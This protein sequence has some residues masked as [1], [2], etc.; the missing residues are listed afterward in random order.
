[1][2]VV[3]EQADSVLEE[4]ACTEVELVA[5]LVPVAEVAALL[6]L[7]ESAPEK[8]VQP[9][10]SVVVE[11]GPDQVLCRTLGLAT[12]SM[13]RKPHIS[14]LGQVVILTR[15]DLEGISLASSRVVVF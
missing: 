6:V 8:S 7:A 5:G 13:F 3:A 2:V 1:M 15:F 11:E 4:V 9:A 12:E 14:M 10:G